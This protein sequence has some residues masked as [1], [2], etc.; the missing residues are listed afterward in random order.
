MDSFHE[1]RSPV[2]SAQQPTPVPL[3]DKNLTK[4]QVKDKNV[5]T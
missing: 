3:E 2:F 1:I 4:L 5:S